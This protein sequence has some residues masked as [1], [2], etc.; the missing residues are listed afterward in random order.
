MNVHRKNLLLLVLGC[1]LSNYDTFLLGTLC[2]KIVPLFVNLDNGQSQTFWAHALVLV[3]FFTRPFGGMVFGYIGDRFSRKTSYITSLFLLSTPSLLL[4]LLPTYE[5]I[6][7]GATIAFTV[8]RLLQGFSTGGTFGGTFTY[9]SE[10][11]SK[12]NPL[13]KSSLALAS[14]FLGVCF[15]LIIVYCSQSIFPQDSELAWRAP[16]IFSVFS[17]MAA[18]F[19]KK[20]FTETPIAV[21]KRRK[22]LDISHILKTVAPLKKEIIACF[23]FGGIN[24]V[25]FHFAT[26]HINF[27]LF[28]YLGFSSDDP[29]IY[30]NNFCFFLGSAA[31]IMFFS[32]LGK[33]LKARKIIEM[34]VLWFVLLSIPMFFY[35]A[36]EMTLGKIIF[37]QAYLAIGNICFLVPIVSLLP[38]SFPHK[39]RFTLFSFTYTL[40]QGVIGAS[41][42]LLTTKI[43]LKTNYL[44]TP[45]I[46]LSIAFLVVWIM[47]ERMNWGID[48][49]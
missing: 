10:H 9:T 31:L 5:V 46:I 29:F 45:S 37:L 15:A 17:F 23:L 7:I 41:I 22:K 33:I 35:T 3:A 6:G 19:I 14:G 20:Q 30:V 34:S 1:A 25:P 28:N 8:L 38:K 11:T 18:F 47:L 16:F 12:V 49:D 48:N 27:L 13:I 39:I 32:F 36:H 42:Q 21:E 24:M 43:I 26:L 4:G 40:G 2:L 44:W